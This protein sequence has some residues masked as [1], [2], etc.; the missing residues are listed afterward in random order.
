[1]TYIC[2]IKYKP[3]QG[4][5]T[6]TVVSKSKKYESIKCISK[7]DFISTRGNFALWPLETLDKITLGCHSC[8]ERYTPAPGRSQGC[9]QT[10]YEAEDSP[11]PEFIVPKKSTVPRVM[12]LISQQELFVY[13]KEERA[14]PVPLRTSC[15]IPWTCSAR[16]VSLWTLVL[17]ST[18]VTDLLNRR[19]ALTN[20][21]V[22]HL[23][24]SETWSALTMLNI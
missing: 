11:Q 7:I 6:L 17:Y 10:A 8:G 1:M 14:F 13:R 2:D 3:F 12:Q 23:P 9:S 4:S 20:D 22:Q 19:H 18:S 5:Q 21:Y 16:R 24:A 15:P